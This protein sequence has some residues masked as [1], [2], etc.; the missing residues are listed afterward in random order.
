MNKLLIIMLS[1]LVISVSLISANTG[2]FSTNQIDVSQALALTNSSFAI[3]YCNQSSQELIVKVINT[4]GTVLSSNRIGDKIGT[5]DENMISMTPI[6]NSNFVVSWGNLTDNSILAA[7]IG[8]DSLIKGSLANFAAGS[9]PYFVSSASSNGSTNWF[10]WYDA[11]TNLVKI[12][13]CRNALTSCSASSITPALVSDSNHLTGIAAFNDSTIVVTWKDATDNQYLKY[14]VISLGTFAD[15]INPFIVVNG[16]IGSMGAS[17]AG[18]ALIAL[19]SS[20][21]VAV[22]NNVTATWFK[23]I[24]TNGN[25]LTDPIQVAL[26]NSSTSDR[27]GISSINTSS[28][29]II[30]SRA[31][32]SSNFTVYDSAGT[33]TAGPVTF[34]E[35]CVSPHQGVSGFTH[36]I[37]TST[38]GNTFVV[39]YE[40][41]TAIANYSTYY[42]NGSLWDGN[43]LTIT[44][45]MN[46]STILPAIAYTTTTLNASCMA[47]TYDGTGTININ[48]TI[49][50]NGV[51]LSTGSLTTQA[52]NTVISI[53]NITGTVA[54]EVYK[55]GC[56]AYVN[57]GEK[58]NELNSSSLTVLSVPMNV[59]VYDEVN[60]SLLLENVSITVSSINESHYNT[61]TS[62]KTTVPIVL[63]GTYTI[64]L[65]SS[66]Y[67]T[68]NYQLEVLGTESEAVVINAYMLKTTSSTNITIYIQDSLN[69]VV[70]NS[71]LIIG[72]AYS[73]NWT[74]VVDTYCD[75]GGRAIVP[76]ESGT[77]Y[78]VTI[79]ASGFPLKQFV[80]VFWLSG[81]P[82]TY[83]LSSAGTSVYTDVFNDVNYTYSPTNTTVS[84]ATTIFT[85]N[86]FSDDS[87]LEWASINSSFNSTNVSDTT[88]AITSISVYLANQS[89]E[90]YPVTYCFKQSSFDQYCFIVTYYVEGR[91][92]S[93]GNL[94]DTLKDFRDLFSGGTSNGWLTI[95]AIFAILILC[96][97]TAE[98]S[99]SPIVTTIAGFG[100]MIV[101]TFIG[102]LNPILTGV[103][104]VIGFTLFLINKQGGG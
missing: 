74:N 43:Y 56:V 39:T 27:V 77:S 25:N 23:I 37:N 24:D 76:L 16:T 6:N 44:P 64:T 11:S 50:K 5:C 71:R 1:L 95:M 81:S 75:D 88:L 52:V 98:L 19:N 33:K 41:T 54:G 40:V 13:K 36:P 100:G 72:R 73:G 69:R 96:V 63:P 48:Y 12:E 45:V 101:F 21:F 15:P 17:V 30:R 31:S 8:N 26:I 82:Y 103:I 34:C 28:F 89:G 86:V 10:A 83:R 42:G 70:P 91:S 97:V 68:K 35:G 22:W 65:S 79:I 4:T 3:A 18:D 78:V 62:G 80:Q 94:I 38:F 92:A 93:G 51:S 57:T 9:L 99:G 85:F 14:A 102:W 90:A 55:L 58:S 53:A 7:N 87:L 46:T 32:S 61:T 84:N 60:G 20:A 59:T 67:A 49:Y 29:V 104:C 2:T 47:D 66:N